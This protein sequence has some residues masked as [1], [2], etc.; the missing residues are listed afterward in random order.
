M[1]TSAPAYAPY[2]L[3]TDAATIGFVRLQGLRED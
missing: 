2:P 3:V 1:S